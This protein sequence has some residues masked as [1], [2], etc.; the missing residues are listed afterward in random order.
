MLKYLFVA[1]LSILLLLSGCT[2]PISTVP[3]YTLAEPIPLSFVFRFNQSFSSSIFYTSDFGLKYSQED[4]YEDKGLQAAVSEIA[5][6]FPLTSDQQIEEYAWELYAIFVEHGAIASEMLP[7]CAY[8]FTDGI[9][10]IAFL[11]LEYWGAYYDG[12]SAAALISEFD[13]HII[14]LTTD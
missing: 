7:M 4:Q 9:W 6:E 1:L 11:P 8:H 14:V 10:Y 3:D 13:G 12:P 2:A 5:A